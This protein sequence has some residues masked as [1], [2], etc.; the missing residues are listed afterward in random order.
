M[1]FILS[2]KKR[3]RKTSHLIV[4]VLPLLFLPS[5]SPGTLQTAKT[6]PPGHF[7]ISLSAGYLHNEM[8]MKRKNPYTA[9][10]PMGG[11]MSWALGPQ[12]S[13]DIRC[14]MGLGAQSSIKYNFIS[15]TQPFALAIQGGFGAAGNVD[16]SLGS[17]FVSGTN[18]AIV[19]IPVTLITSYDIGP[20]VTPYVSVGYGAYW[21][22]GYKKY[23]DVDPTATT[24]KRRGH[25][26]GLLN[27]RAGLSIRL[28]RWL[29]I[30]AG[31][32][33]SRRVLD[34][35]GDFYS[36]SHS[37][38]ALFGVLFRLESVTHRKK[39]LLIEDPPRHRYPKKPPAK[40]LSPKAY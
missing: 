40:R 24:E 20:W 4:L 14:F 2:T 34:D 32:G 9:N 39:R 21:I 36:F 37:H 23:L 16:P 3:W 30:M 5:C 33:Y 7:D 13:M 26:D 31:Y 35:P 1:M 22:F 27:T 15:P 11:G 29:Y 38:M 12:L 8:V 19:H 6:T 28:K 17:A 18:A 25:G 10:F